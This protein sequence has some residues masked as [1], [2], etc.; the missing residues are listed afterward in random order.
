MESAAYYPP[1]ILAFNPRFIEIREVESGRL[2]QAIK[3]QDIKCLWSGGNS[4]RLTSKEEMGDAQKR[5]LH[6]HVTMRTEDVDH[7]DESGSEGK[8]RHGMFELLPTDL[9]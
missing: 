8:P 4:G 1:Y 3:G 2:V 9:A 7:R 6:I 5:D